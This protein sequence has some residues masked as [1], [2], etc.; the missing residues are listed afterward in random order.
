MGFAAGNS[1][2]QACG[3]CCVG[4]FEMPIPLHLSARH[5]EEMSVSDWEWGIYKLITIVKRRLDRIRLFRSYSTYSE[6]KQFMTAL[7]R[8]ENLASAGEVMKKLG[9]YC[10]T[11]SMPLGSGLEATS[12]SIK[13]FP[14]KGEPGIAVECTPYKLDDSGWFSFRGLLKQVLG[15]G[16]KHVAG[17]F[18]LAKVE[19][20]MDVKAPFDDLLC[21]APGMETENLSYLK[22]GTR[23]LG[24]KWGKR[25]FC[26]Y[27]K[28]KQL[29]EKLAVDL[30]HNLTRIE[31][32]L[33]HLGKTMA[34][35]P[36]IAKPFGE[37]LVVRRAALQRLCE[38]CPNEG[39][40][41]EFAK[42][43]EGGD[44]AHAFYLQLSKHYRKRLRALILPHSIRLNSAEEVWGE[45]IAGQ[46]KL[47]VE[48][49]GK[50]VG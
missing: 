37:L 6:K 10:T 35:M 21:I 15:A 33:R 40:L 24:Q 31:V 4:L 8:L 38:T 1:W 7:G 11:Y 17:Q 27:D 44:G 12:V 42:W 50:E 2:R 41:Q 39:V 3:F 9:K 26:I 14:A 34:E 18:V 25:T 16:A 19:V 5:G 29:A 22:K 36:G 20:A 47:L 28:R 43:V 49:F 46:S 13:L 48:N 32:R 30:G 45:W 23:Y